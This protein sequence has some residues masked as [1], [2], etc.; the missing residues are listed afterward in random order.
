MYM[1]YLFNLLSLQCLNISELDHGHGPNLFIVILVTL[2][3]SV[4]HD[5]VDLFDL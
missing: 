3:M 4:I 5:V 1:L 2:L